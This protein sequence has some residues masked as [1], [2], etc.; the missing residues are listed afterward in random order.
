MKETRSVYTIMD[1]LPALVKFSI[2][3]AAVIA[4]L[5]DRGLDPAMPYSDVDANLRRLCY[6]DELRWYLRGESKKNNVSDS[7]NGWSHSGGGYELSDDD[8]RRLEDEANSI[9]RELEPESVIKRRTSFRMLSNGIK[10]ANVDL[11]GDPLPRINR[12]D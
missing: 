9:Y 1:H 5:A 10:P 7:D 11:S 4:I 6:A 3:K 12:R 2:P 8:R